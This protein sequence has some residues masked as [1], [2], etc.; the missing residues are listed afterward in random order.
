MTDTVE[1]LAVKSNP[2]EFVVSCDPAVAPFLSSAIA[3]R[4]SN[5]RSLL[6]S[7]VVH[8]ILLL[9][10][11]ALPL[12]SIK[13][14]S[15]V[16]RSVSSITLAP[17]PPQPEAPTPLPR[18][19]RVP[20]P[21]AVAPSALRFTPP[22]VASASTPTPKLEVRTEPAPVISPP[23][24]SATAPALELPTSTPVPAPPREIKTNVFAG[25]PV[26]SGQS[27]GKSRQVESAG[28]GD[29]NGMR[30]EA[31]KTGKLQTASLGA[32]DGGCCGQGGSGTGRKGT[33]GVASS[34]FNNNVS[35]GGAS[36][37]SRHAVQQGVFG[38]PQS[39]SPVTTQKRTIEP[40]RT[41]VDIQFKPKPA[42]TDQA[43]AMKIEGEVLLK[44]IFAATGQ[45]RIVGVVKGLGYGLDESAVAS[46]ER[47][48]FK[49]AQ[50]DGNA[51]DSPAV[52]HI[53]FK[54]ID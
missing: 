7:L 6:T 24:Q 9:V 27:E 36:N 22:P 32:F 14:Y 18:P 44:V 12:T 34:G 16:K 17:L 53:V 54:L 10:L 50:L 39:D 49:P 51:V 28:F 41:P 5:W 8:S 3:N 11:I 52:L 19:V 21:V 40:I 25:S 38:A 35:G 33:G 43:R 1:S 37:G 42:Y 2:G 47:I 45:I 30:P 20:P 46:A 15:P 48:V 31:G 29:P 13:N 23:T 4:P 26:S